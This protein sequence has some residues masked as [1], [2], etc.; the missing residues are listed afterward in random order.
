METAMKVRQW[1]LVD[2]KSMRSV[3]R[4]TGLSRNT[5]SKYC[6]DGT[7]PK[8]ERTKSTVCQK[9]KDYETRLTQWFEQDLKRPKRER[10]TA[11]KLYEQL[12]AEGYQGSYATLSRFIKTLK[13]K[14]TSTVE[15][16]VPL[17]FKPG[18]AMQFDW[19]LEVV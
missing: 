13:S 16:F 5:I 14:Q 11:T 18:N 15:A 10:R 8:Y 4:K 19:S 7:P 6:K 9:L 2:G 3:A 17:F 1:V 12:I